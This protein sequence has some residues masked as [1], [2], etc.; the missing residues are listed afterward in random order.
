MVKGPAS[1]TPINSTVGLI[2]LS[3][4][5]SSEFA[6]S[7]ESHSGKAPGALFECAPPH[8]S[9]KSFP[10][11]RGATVLV[12]KNGPAASPPKLVRFR[13][14]AYPREVPATL[15]L[16]AETIK[17]AGRHSPVSSQD[18]DAAPEN[19]TRCDIRRIRDGEIRC[20]ETQPS[21]LLPATPEAA[22]DCCKF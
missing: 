14:I 16:A 6:A 11:P 20:A 21:P 12:E 5:R 2:R 10:W 15:H 7:T 4:T 22:E 19:R 17:L 1:S 13:T 3:S 9:D 18:L 8:P